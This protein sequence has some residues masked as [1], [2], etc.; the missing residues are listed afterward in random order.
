M[1]TDANRNGVAK[2]PADRQ[3]AS[4]AKPKPQPKPYTFPAGGRSL[5]PGYRLVALYGT[6]G[7]PALG[8][9]GEQDAGATIAR[10]KQLAAAYQPLSQQ[11]I[12]PTLEI[13]ATVASA[14][15]TDDGDYS[16]AIDAATIQPW[17]TLAAQQGVYVVLDLQSGRSDF[18]S[19]AKQYEAL[20]RQPNVGLA[21]D[22]EWRLAPNQ[23]PLVQIGTV[24]IQEINQTAAW[25]ADLTRTDHLPQK[26]L[27]LHQFRIDM[28]PE[29][30][31][32]DTSHSQLAYAIQ[33]D[34][35][36]SQAGKQ[37][38]WQTITASPPANVNFGWKN[39]YDEDHPMLTPEQTMA[40]T[41]Q[42]WYISYQ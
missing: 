40:I 8:V 6:P 21:L 22:P 4:V 5:T 33:M 18:L 34:G 42:P 10:V 32:L 20:L 30:S 28:I 17:I 38:T 35:Q 7:D 31:Q 39:F 9:L 23:V 24:G 37:D 29:R 3:P 2:L 1:T 36:G 41:P 19:Q 26:L 27:L 25:L 11:H 15:P 16:Q 14:Y 12:L 13:I